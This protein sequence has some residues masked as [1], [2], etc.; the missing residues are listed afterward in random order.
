MN[1]VRR[2]I[3]NNFGYIGFGNN[4]K[5][6]NQKT[7]IPFSVLKDKLNSEAHAHVQLHFK[8]QNL[9]QADKELIKKNIRR[10]AKQ[11]KIK[12]FILFII[13]FTAAILFIKLLI[14]QFMANI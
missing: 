8:H 4:Q 10:A 9:T 5:V 13:F 11:Q 14:D 6:F 2:R 7:T 12:I 3:A 1:R